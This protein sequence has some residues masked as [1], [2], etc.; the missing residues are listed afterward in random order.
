M[1]AV[2]NKIETNRHSLN[3]C[4]KICWPGSLSQLNQHVQSFLSWKQNK[5]FFHETTNFHIKQSCY[6]LGDWQLISNNKKAICFKWCLIQIV[7]DHRRPIRTSN[8][9]RLFDTSKNWFCPIKSGFSFSESRS[10]MN[11]QQW[12]NHEISC[13]SYLFSLS[14]LPPHLHNVPAAHSWLYFLL[15]P[16]FRNQACLATVTYVSLP[17]FVFFSSTGITGLHSHVLFW[18]GSKMYLTNTFGTLYFFFIRGTF[19]NKR[20]RS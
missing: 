15:L 5:P 12:N 18:G 3:T 20:M 4:H 1:H 7:A 9:M 16:T 6:W 10:V 19:K 8:G 17:Y 11:W 2:L 14:K 13:K